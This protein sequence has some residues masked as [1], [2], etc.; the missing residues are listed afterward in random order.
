[1]QDSKVDMETRSALA[2][3]IKSTSLLSLPTS[4]R[5][6]LLTMLEPQNTSF[7][8]LNFNAMKQP[9]QLIVNALL[10]LVS[11]ALSTGRGFLVEF[12]ENPSDFTQKYLPTSPENEEAVVISK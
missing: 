1:M 12:M 7:K 11:S 3:W 6:L 2:T 10:A 4:I 8:L 5:S 9:Q